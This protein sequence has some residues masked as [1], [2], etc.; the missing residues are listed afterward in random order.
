MKTIKFSLY[1][2][3]LLFAL[4]ALML[5]ISL[6]VE[7]NFSAGLISYVDE[8]LCIV[9]TIYIVYFSLK[10]GIK[11]NDLLLLVLLIILSLYTLIGN[12]VSKV[13]TEFMPI[14][15]DLVCLAKIFT[16]FIVYKHVAMYD[17]KHKLM[18]Y[19]VPSAKLLIIAESIC[20]IISMF[21]NIGMTGDRRYGIPSYAFLFA[22]EARNGYITAC[23]LLILMVANVPKKNLRIYEIMTVFIL[24]ITTKGVVYIMLI[25]YLILKIMWLNNKK[26]KFTVKNIITIVIGVIAISGYQIDTYLRD[27]TSPRSLFIRY[28]F[29]TANTYFPFGS[30]FAT[31]GS[32]MAGRYYSSLYI[33]YGF[34]NIYGMSEDMGMFLN[35]CYLGMVLGQFGYIGTIIFVAMLVII[36]IS[37]NRINNLGRDTKALIL[38]IFIGIVVSS[39]GTA[40]IKS[41]IGV[42]IF[43]ILGT[44]CGYS[45]NASLTKEAESTLQPSAE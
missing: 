5:P 44:I 18:D 8:V 9:C 25:C 33:Q 20:G 28:G 6:I 16:P 40:I 1:P 3:E 42:F 22:N 30:G 14:A 37:L 41:S 32:D 7:M 12:A 11:G 29:R 26:L 15:V 43:A 24:I 2:R 23:A 34:N 31:Y 38:A 19:L 13:T 35:D 17:K 27:D 45:R 36:F 10:K 4:F 21:V 39:L